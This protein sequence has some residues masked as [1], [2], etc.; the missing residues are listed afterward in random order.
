MVHP[1]HCPT[2][3]RRVWL[4]WRAGR[5]CDWRVAPRRA[6]AM[7]KVYLSIYL[8][9]FRV[10][11]IRVSTVPRRVWSIWRVGQRCDWWVAARRA[12]ATLSLTKPPTLRTRSRTCTRR[13]TSKVLRKWRMTRH[14]RCWRRY[15]CT[16]KEIHT[17]YIYI[18]IYM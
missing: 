4:I 16:E 11:L 9:I 6:G 17:C 12:G 14:A 1:I 2:V 18:Y 7:P 10:H 5:R 8:S 3:L 15:G 13:E